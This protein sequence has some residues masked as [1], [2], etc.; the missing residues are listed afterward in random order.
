[1]KKHSQIPP[2]A[3]LTGMSRNIIH[4]SAGLLL[5]IIMGCASVSR[6]VTIMH[7]STPSE[8]DIAT[9]YWESHKQPAEQARQG[10]ANQ[11]DEAGAAVGVP[12]SAVSTEGTGTVGAPE[13]HEREL[14]ENITA[15][16][17]QEV[18]N[19]VKEE[20]R[21]DVMDEMYREIWKVDWAMKE[22]DKRI[23][24]GGD[25]RLR[26]EKDIFGSNNAAF[27]QPSDPSELMNTTIDQDLFK[28]RVRFG[29]EAM[30]N[31]QMDAVIRLSTGNTTNPVSTNATMGNY[32]NKDSIVFDLAYLKWRPW[33]SVT[34]YGGRMPNPFFS[35]DLLWAKDLN[36]EGFALH[37]RLPT[38]NVDSWT[39]FF[40]AGA[41]P[42][43]Q[44]AFGSEQKWLLA[45]QV[46]LDRKSQKGVAVK[47][48][49]AYY[50]FKNITGI[51]NDPNSPGDTNWTA[52][53]FQQKGNTLFNIS[54]NPSVIVTALAS[55]FKELDITGTLDIGFWD[56]IHVALLG[57]YVKNFGFNQADV[58]ART[59]IPNPPEQV[60]GYQYGV[61]IGHPTTYESGQWKVYFYV[62][63][64]E[65]DAVVDGFTDPDFHLG[66]TNA[67]GWILETDVG[68][69]KNSWLTLKWL[70]ADEISGPPLAIDVL[71]VDL[72]ARF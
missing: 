55:E 47:I 37:A 4:G 40:T 14:I 60:E 26:Y 20:V 46:G 19:A 5:S 3:S 68:L 70:T 9:A 12:S 32:M 66:G 54:S 13:A 61:S 30:I 33:N 42:L 67:K 7:E 8:S 62:K 51:P 43:E 48:G 58:A 53:L 10:N 64:L 28:Y 72:N 27:A 41:F 15:R 65:A 69:L 31:D 21:N 6:P 11:H 16:V 35:T 63:H 44:N 24:F 59:G 52:P 23:R 71:Q 18:E 1:M 45:S 29:A 17:T 25:I 49:S 56:P 36:F 38:P 50:D 39:P 22:K 34:L 57:D 2:L